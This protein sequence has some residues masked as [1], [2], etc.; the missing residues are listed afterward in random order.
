MIPNPYSWLAG[1][2]LVAGVLGGMYAYG[3]SDGR[4]AQAKADAAEIAEAR[5]HR[6]E[7]QRALKANARAFRAYAAI[8]HANER[9][10]AARARQRQVDEAF[11]V[12]SRKD[13]ERRVAELAHAAQIERVT[14]SQ[15]EM[16]ICGAPLR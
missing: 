4:E 3:R 13:L 16:R 5:G 1:L 7:L 15:A 12:G 2:V 11:A 10:A 8:A 6:V 14:C 9:A